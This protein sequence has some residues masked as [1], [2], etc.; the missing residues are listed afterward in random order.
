MTSGGKTMTQ[1]CETWAPHS[2]DPT[3]AALLA[4]ILAGAFWA[5]LVALTTLLTTLL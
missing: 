5:A 3:S 1:A 2:V 4:R